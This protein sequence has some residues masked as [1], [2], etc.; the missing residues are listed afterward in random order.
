LPHDEKS[1]T[2][3]TRK[4]NPIMNKQN[5][6]HQMRRTFSAL[7]AAGALFTLPSATGDTRLMA[8]G[9][10]TDCE[11][12]ISVTPYPG[13]D[14]VTLNITST[15]TGTFDG[16][17]VGT[18]EDVVYP[19]GYFTV[20]AEGTFTGSVAGSS[21]TVRLTY[22]AAVPPTGGITPKPGSPWYVDQGTG[23]LAGL[24]GKGMWVDFHHLGPTPECDDSFSSRY[25][26]EISFAP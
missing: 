9:S 17:W 12:V 21:G 23:A 24:R 25:V 18:E 8:T 11:H 15:Y 19:D 2:A 7:A 20:H 14:V 6:K 3:K 26:G 22:Y 1:K 13:Y 10:W 5:I 16:T 4:G